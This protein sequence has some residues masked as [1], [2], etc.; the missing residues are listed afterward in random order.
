[1]INGKHLI[2]EYKEHIIYLFKW[3]S[4]SVIIGGLIGSASA[5]LLHSLE[6]A[7]TYR[8]NNMWSIALLPLAGLGIGLL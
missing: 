2:S 1:M 6:F 4:L 3:L 7:T 5:I 8:E